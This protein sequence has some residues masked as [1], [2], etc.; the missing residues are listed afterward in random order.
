MNEMVIQNFV[1]ITVV[2]RP[3]LSAVSSR[4]HV[5]QSGWDSDFWSLQ[6][7]YKEA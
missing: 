7:W 1:V 2:L 4:L 6:N 5:E 3:R